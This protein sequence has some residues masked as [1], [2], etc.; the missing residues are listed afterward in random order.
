MTG[1]AADPADLA[2]IRAE[3]EAAHD[4]ASRE[5]LVEVARVDDVDAGGV[6]ARLYQPDHPPGAMLLLHGGGFVYG[7][8]VTHDGFAR[9]LA[10]RTGWTVLL[11]DYR[12]APEHPWPAA[13]EDT[14][15]AADW[16]AGLGHDRLIVV[17][18]SAGAALALGE[19]M[20]HRRRYAGQVLVY[21]FIDPSTA[22]YDGS[23]PGAEFSL[24]Q[25]EWFW[26]LYLQSADASAD[27]A[28]HALERDVSGLPRTLVQ[29]A[30][31]DIL[32]STGR[33]L[34]E[35]L[36]R[37][38]VTVTTTVYP[39]VQHGFWRRTD[40]DRSEPALDEIAKFIAAGC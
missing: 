8:R 16:L 18:D 13:D 34:A 10:A 27:D 1:W 37:S 24:E 35:H 29:L 20:R 39:E 26:D 19:A 11:P 33:Q 30:G 23:L 14:A 6:P 12:R 31:L 3:R 36:A 9:R 5:T 2:E 25:A 17:G 4:E 28:L 40:N 21:P 15:L 32:T 22:S 7:D 38:G